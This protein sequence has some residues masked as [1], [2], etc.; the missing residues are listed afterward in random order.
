M[1]ILERVHCSLQ[2]CASGEA[3]ADYPDFCP[4][5]A[6]ALYTSIHIMKGY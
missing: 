2:V 5:P 1:M 3:E 4:M 6:A